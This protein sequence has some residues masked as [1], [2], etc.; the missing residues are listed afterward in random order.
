M[1]ATATLESTEAAVEVP[2]LEFVASLSNASSSP[3]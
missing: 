2:V 1:A 3:H